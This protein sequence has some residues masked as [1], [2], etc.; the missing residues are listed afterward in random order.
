VLFLRFASSVLQ[1]EAQA[2]LLAVRMTQ[3]LGGSNVFFYS[4]CKVLMEAAMSDDMFSKNSHSIIRHI[5]A[6]VLVCRRATEDL[7]LKVPHAETR[8]CMR[9]LSAPFGIALIPAQLFVVN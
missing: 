8:Q 6:D 7:V 1:A 9:L 4:D 2:L 3:L 5:L